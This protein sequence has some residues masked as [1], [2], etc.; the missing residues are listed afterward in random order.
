[1]NRD[2]FEGWSQARLAEVEH[3][4]ER[5]V[6]EQA[7]AGLGAAMRY[8][9]L[10]GGKRLRFTDVTAAAGTSL[11]AE[12]F[13]SEGQAVN[14]RLQRKGEGEDAGKVKFGPE[15]PRIQTAIFDKLTADE[16]IAFCRANMAHFKTPKTI[17]FGPLPKTS[18][19]KVQK[20]V[21]RQRAK[22]LG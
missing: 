14:P 5:F 13:N 9:V 12:V 16:L 2:A 8:G 19:G 22:E 15:P 11:E 21:L 20:F 1:M 17:V 18:T 7:P 4:L 6:P 3:A 10:D